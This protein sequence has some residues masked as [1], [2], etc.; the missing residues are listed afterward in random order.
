MDPSFDAKRNVQEAIG[1]AVFTSNGRSMYPVGIFEDR[2]EKTENYVGCS[3][4]NQLS[5]S[6]CV[7]SLGCLFSKADQ[8]EDV[9]VFL[10]NT[11]QSWLRVT[12]NP[13]AKELKMLSTMFQITQWLFLNKLRIQNAT[14]FQNHS[15]FYLERG[16]F[17]RKDYRSKLSTFSSEINHCDVI[18]FSLPFSSPR[19]SEMESSQW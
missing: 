6:D 4:S 15:F 9:S 8:H 18:C 5:C 1:L 16:T 3:R 19:L 2:E 17:I 12:V 7:R 11:E 14:N 10:S 13:K